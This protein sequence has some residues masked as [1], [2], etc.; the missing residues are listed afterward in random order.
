M[1]PE[2]AEAIECLPCG[3][4]YSQLTGE[5]RR[6]YHKSGS[7]PT[8]VKKGYVIETHLLCGYVERET[9]DGAP[10]PEASG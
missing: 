8:F 4:K 9:L 5:N 10:A 2:Y 1:L 7:C 6:L 3:R